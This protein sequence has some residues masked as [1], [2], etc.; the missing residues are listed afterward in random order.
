MRN[1]FRFCRLLAGLLGLCAGAL[2]AQSTTAGHRSGGTHA[3][4]LDASPPANP[5]GVQIVV[6][7]DGNLNPELIPDDLA[8]LHFFRALAKNPAAD[9]AAEER[10]RGAYLRYF[11]R[12][13]C[14]PSATQ[15]RS[16]NESQTQRLLA[17]ADQTAALLLAAGAPGSSGGGAAPQRCHDIVTAAMSSLDVSVDPDG[18]A[19]IR[20]HVAEHV[21]RRIQLVSVTMPMQTAQQPG[22]QGQ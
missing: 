10:R 22:A 3:A 1:S 12:R 8:Y 13:G 18:A 9:Q 20:Q 5:P 2:S 16:L 14:G 4:V 7:A 6:T 15:D 17:L 21:K 11:F 19:K